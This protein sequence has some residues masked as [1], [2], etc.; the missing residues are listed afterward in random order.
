MKEELQMKLLRRLFNKKHENLIDVW[1]GNQWL[2][3]KE[4]K[5]K[6]YKVVSDRE[7]KKYLIK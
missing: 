5:L 2:K 3:V 6:K 7:G 1:H 4:S